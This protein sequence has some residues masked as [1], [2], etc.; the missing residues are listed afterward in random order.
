[1]RTKRKDRKQHAQREK[2]DGKEGSAKKK[3]RVRDVLRKQKGGKKNKNGRE[4][5]A[6]RD[7][8]KKK[9]KKRK[10][11]GSDGK[12]LAARVRDKKNKERLNRRHQ[13][14]ICF[15]LC[16]CLFDSPATSSPHVNLLV[17]CQSHTHTH[18]HRPAVC[19]CVIYYI[20]LCDKFW[21]RFFIFLFGSPS[22][23]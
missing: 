9:K 20:L 3:Q 1:M 16:F 13:V 17:P 19:M 23:V 15:V 5:K 6:A 21:A 4:K 14:Y 7:R 10:K 11:R 8:K 2:L 22:C 12:N 18:R